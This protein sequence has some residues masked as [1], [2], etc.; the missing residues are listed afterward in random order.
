MHE[1]LKKKKDKQYFN[2]QKIIGGI[3]K[4][5]VLKSLISY[6]KHAKFQV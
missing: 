5:I 6:A 4:G 2:N 3:N 1:E